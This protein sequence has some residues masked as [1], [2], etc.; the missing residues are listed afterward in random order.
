MPLKR[1][2]RNDSSAIRENA[3]RHLFV[4]LISV[5]LLA[6][7]PAALLEVSGRSLSGSDAVSSPTEVID[8][9]SG[10]YVVL[11]NR[12]MH[13][14]EDKL[15]TW[16][17]F[18]SGGEI[19]YLFEDISCAV[20]ANDTQGTDIAR[21]F[22]SR[23]PENQMKIRSFDDSVLFL[24]KAYY[25]HF[26]I[27]LMSAEAYRAYKADVLADRPFAECLNVNGGSV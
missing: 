11:I 9:P 17:V 10:D 3:A 26:D 5:L 21:S 13:T 6:G 15:D 18:F 19:G 23:L 1:Q 20:L 14:D 24:S 12:D 27:I 2:N 25:G 7:L 8:R 4:C 22:A 16:K